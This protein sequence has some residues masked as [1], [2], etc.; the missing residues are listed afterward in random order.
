MEF[1]ESKLSC[2]DLKDE[3]RK[4]LLDVPLPLSSRKKSF[5][6]QATSPGFGEGDTCLESC[7]DLSSDLIFRFTGHLQR[8]ESPLLRVL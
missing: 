1:S 4:L 2:S 3:I 8:G 7:F 5:V 6:M